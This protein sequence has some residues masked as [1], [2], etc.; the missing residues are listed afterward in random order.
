MRDSLQTVYEQ[1]MLVLRD[2]QAILKRFH[3]S[4]SIRLESVCQQGRPPAGGR[5]FIPLA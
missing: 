5:Q 4:R 3:T 2:E 1:G